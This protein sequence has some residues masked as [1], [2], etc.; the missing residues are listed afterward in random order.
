LAR[1]IYLA[2][3]ERDIR[4]L[5]KTFLENEGYQVETFE[6]GSSIR[7]AFDRRVPDLVILDVMMP[8]EDGLSVCTYIRKKSGVP[9][10]I[11]SAK[12]TPFDRVTGITLGSDDYLTKPVL[13]L[14]L[15]ARV[16]AMFRRIDLTVREYV[17]VPD[18]PFRCGNLELEPSA[19]KIRIAGQPFNV[20]PTEFEFLQYLIRHSQTAVSKH[21]LLKQ[22]WKFNDADVDSRVADDLIKRLRKKMKEAGSTAFIETVWGYGYRMEEKKA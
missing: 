5:M 21:E 18:G 20:T 3:D 2:D 22:V 1:L 16:K 4:L 13:P 15:V 12:D 19:R 7:E 11:V 14:E 17:P 8:G 9:I 6:N 10:M